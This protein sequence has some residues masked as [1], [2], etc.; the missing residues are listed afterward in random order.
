VV[1]VLL[2]LA[3]LGAIY[4][5]IASANERRAYPPPGQLVDIGGY[6]LHL[7]CTGQGSPTVVFEGGLGAPAFAWA[8]VQPEVAT[9]TRACSYDRAGLGWSDP[10]PEP[11]TGQQMVTE[12]ATLLH[13]AGESGPYILVGHS[14][15]GLNTR[16]FAAQ[17]PTDVAGIVL[18]DASHEAQS[19]RMPA[20]YQQVDAANLQMNMLLRIASRLGITRLLDALGLLPSVESL[21]GP[22]PRDVL[23]V[24]AA[25]LVHNPSQWDT[26]Y[27]ELAVLDT[28]M[29]QIAAL[30]GM[31]GQPPLGNL[32]LVVITAARPAD[33]SRLPRDFPIQEGR[34]VWLELQD[35][36][37]TLASNSIHLVA[38]QSD[39]N[40]PLRQP[41]IIIDAIRQMI[42]DFRG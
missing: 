41:Q 39:H 8:W 21:V 20:A 19:E 13:D 24:A 22:L 6:K 35:D 3:F 2:A 5:A 25:F 38:E 16:L 42:A 37:A 30:R 7:Y 10:G 9:M 18:V 15:G 32:P 26:G 40:I 11:R 14:L 12:L 1:L 29:A 36:L 34:R 31:L 17:Y 28:D 23:P 4:Q 33:L 27:A